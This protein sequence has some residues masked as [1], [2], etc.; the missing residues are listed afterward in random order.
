M[1]S[2]LVIAF[3]VLGASNVCTAQV[4]DT[5]PEKK[6]KIVALLPNFFEWPQDVKPVGGAPYKIGVLGSDPFKQGAVNHLDKQAA[7]GKIVIERF[8]DIGNY[9]PCHIL[10]VSSSAD[11]KPVLEKT[12]EQPVLVVAE[13]PGLAKEGAVVNLVFVRQI[14]RLQIEFNPAEAKLAGLKT[15]NRFES[16]SKKIQ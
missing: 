12:R 10:V 3:L 4:I 15:K 11:L 5:A 9:R 14:N 8:A 7:G 2:L 16:I 6:A 1:V 13:A